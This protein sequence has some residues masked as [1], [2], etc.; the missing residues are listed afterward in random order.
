[1]DLGKLTNLSFGILFLLIES[2]C[3]NLVAKPLI[4]EL[5]NRVWNWCLEWLFM[6]VEVKRLG[7]GQNAGLQSCS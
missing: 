3:E 2:V 6:E 1:M 7:F 4:F 5:I